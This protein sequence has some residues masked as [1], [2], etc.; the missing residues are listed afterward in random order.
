MLQ[1]PEAGKSWWQSAKL[2]PRQ[3]EVEKG[4][5]AAGEVGQQFDQ[6]VAQD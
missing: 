1:L 2:I 4:S 5:K 3:I 6:V